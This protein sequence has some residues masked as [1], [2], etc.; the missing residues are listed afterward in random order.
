MC[1]VAVDI[2]CWKEPLRTSL[3]RMRPSR[4]ERLYAVLTSV[5]HTVW[6]SSFKGYQSLHAALSSV[7]D[8]TMLAQSSFIRV[9]Y[10]S[11]FSRL[12]DLCLLD[13]AGRLESPSESLA[14]PP[15]CVPVLKF[16]V[17]MAS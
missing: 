10:I 4:R 9:G 3:R 12:S 1:N 6:H 17:F 13:S 14:S 11:C 2:D 7:S 15:L 5:G 16:F 8:L